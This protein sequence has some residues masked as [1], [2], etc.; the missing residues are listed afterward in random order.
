[1]LAMDPDVARELREAGASDEEVAELAELAGQ[2][3]SLPESTPRKAWLL[4]S[5]WRLLRRFD[6]LR[7]ER[8]SDEGDRPPA[9]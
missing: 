7:A 1:M 6:E 5:K 2:I 8:A 9:E 4:E 3:E